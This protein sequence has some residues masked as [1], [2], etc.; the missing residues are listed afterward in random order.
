[1]GGRIMSPQFLTSSFVGRYSRKSSGKLRR[2]PDWVGMPRNWRDI[3]SSSSEPRFGRIRPWTLPLTIQS[4]PSETIVYSM[5]HPATEDTDV[6]SNDERRRC[7]GVA[8]DCKFNSY[9]KGTG[10]PTVPSAVAHVSSAVA[11]YSSAWASSFLSFLYMSSRFTGSTWRKVLPKSS[12]KTTRSS[13]RSQRGSSLPD[14]DDGPSVRTHLNPNS[15]ISPSGMA[16]QNI[17]LFRSPSSSTLRGGG[18][19]RC[20]SLM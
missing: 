6:P 2:T 18:K 9:V 19:S 5:G 15:S 14:D 4:D 17:P 13:G 20:H 1:M 10:C 11:V 16:W 3:L 7:R 8:R 12:C